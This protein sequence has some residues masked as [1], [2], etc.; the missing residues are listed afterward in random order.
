MVTTVKATTFV[1][2]FRSGR[3]CPCLMLCEDDK[4]NQIE[5][6]VKLSV[7]NEC[8]PTGLVCELAASFLAQDLDL[9]VPEPFLVDID[10]DFYKGVSDPGLAERFLKSSG[11]NFGSRNLGP[12]YAIWPQERILTDSIIQDAADIFAFDMTIQNPDRRKEKPNLLRKGDEMVIFDHEMAFS[13]LYSFLTNE[14]PWDGKGMGFAKNHLFFNGLKGKMLS[15]AR[16]Q[17]AL[18]A[19]DDRRIGRYIDAIPDGWKGGSGDAPIR[20]QEYL[21]Q[22]RDN[23]K[24]LFRRIEEVLS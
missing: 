7:G 3:T 9:S 8:A 13:F 19:I 24:M 11:L 23:S 18:E 6:V 2:P 22:A 17:G 21:R 15:L 12:G 20:I 1:K 14:Y 4:G 5:M 16:M 10:A